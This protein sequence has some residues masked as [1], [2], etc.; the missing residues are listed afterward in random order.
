MNSIRFLFIGLLLCLGFLLGEA[1]L[2][3]AQNLFSTDRDTNQVKFRLP[4]SMVNDPLKVPNWQLKPDRYPHLRSPLI[5]DPRTML[6]NWDNRL[7]FLKKRRVDPRAEVLAET[8]RRFMEFLERERYARM[9]ALDK[10]RIKLGSFAPVLDA[11][12]TLASMQMGALRAYT[13][14][15]DFNLKVVPRSYFSSESMEE[16]IQRNAYEDPKSMAFYKQFLWMEKNGWTR[17]A[18]AMPTSAIS[19]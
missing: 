13:Y 15:A 11:I 1:D 3:H 18:A 8:N 19:E 6:L 16:R 14:G 10:L 9:P 12:A 5:Q 17:P 7:D 2:L 4:E